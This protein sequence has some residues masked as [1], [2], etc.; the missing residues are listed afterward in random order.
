MIMKSEFKAMINNID[1]EH[2][3]MFCMFEEIFS[4]LET[5]AKNYINESELSDLIIY[6][7][8]NIFYEF[9]HNIRY[10]EDY[11]DE[12]CDEILFYFIIDN[13]THDLT[14]NIKKSE[15]K[16]SLY[17]KNKKQFD[18]YKDFDLNV[19]DMLNV[20]FTSIISL[21]N[22]KCDLNLKNILIKRYDTENVTYSKVFADIRKELTEFEKDYSIF[23]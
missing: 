19:N 12:K 10:V 20:K 15:E 13:M 1:V 22:V 5:Y 16:F 18:I 2:E 7:C 14:L 8:Q 21:H 4:E 23:N 6:L 17:V 11:D 3:H 9:K